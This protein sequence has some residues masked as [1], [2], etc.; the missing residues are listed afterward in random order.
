MTALRQSALMELEKLPEDKLSFIIQIMQGVN[1]LY[2]DT[3]SERKEAFARLE[4]L[5]RKGTVT[6]DDVE[7]ASYRE[8][9]YGN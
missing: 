5:R 8:E 6:D 7:L 9:K 4:Q 3:K 2:N 1:G